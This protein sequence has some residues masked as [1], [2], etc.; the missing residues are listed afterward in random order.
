MNT[1]RLISVVLMLAGAL[2]LGY[3]GFNYTRET[4]QVDV[5]PLHMQMHERGHVTIPVWA[6]I[7]SLIAGLALLGYSSRTH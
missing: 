3:G 7:A 2:A 6:G 1:L 4:H 5:G